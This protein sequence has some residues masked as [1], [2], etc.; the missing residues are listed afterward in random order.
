[1]KRPKHKNHKKIKRQR[2]KEL[3]F[4]EAVRLY[5]GMPVEV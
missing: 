1:M 3:T 5:A 2:K 4:L